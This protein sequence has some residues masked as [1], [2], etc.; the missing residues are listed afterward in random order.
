MLPFRCQVCHTAATLASAYQIGE[1]ESAAALNLLYHT[2]RVVADT[3]FSLAR[4]EYFT[5]D[6]NM[7]MSN[8]VVFSTGCFCLWVAG[9]IL[10]TA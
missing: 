6:K 2:P 1:K 7:P 3:L 9:S 4:P 8:R 10:C 5:I